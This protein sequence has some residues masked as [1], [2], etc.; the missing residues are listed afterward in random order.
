MTRKGQCKPTPGRHLWPLL[1]VPRPMAVPGR[2]RTKN[3]NGMERNLR[4]RNGICGLAAHRCMLC[5]QHTSP[6]WQQF[7]YTSLQWQQVVGTVLQPCM[8]Q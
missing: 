2:R 1:G 4:A 3:C 8:A 5:T 6:I 7:T